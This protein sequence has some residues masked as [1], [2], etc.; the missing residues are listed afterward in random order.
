MKFNKEAHILLAKV[1][2]V[3]NT[4][5]TPAATDCFPLLAFTYDDGT[6]EIDEKRYLGDALDRS[7][8]IT[9]KDQYTKMSGDMYMPIVG[10]AIAVLSDFKTAPLFQASGA[11]VAL[12]GTTTTAQIVITNTIAQSTLLTCEFRQS[13]T[14]DSQ[15]NIYIVPN[16]IATMDFS[17]VIGERVTLKTNIMGNFTTPTFGAGVTPTYGTQKDLKAGSLKSSN[18]IVSE[19][20]GLL[21]GF[22]HTGAAGTVKNVCFEKITCTNVFGFSHERF[23]TSCQ[24][25]FDTTATVGDF[26]ITVLDK[27]MVAAGSES[28]LLWSPYNHSG[29]KHQFTLKYGVG[30][31]K[32]VSIHFSELQLVGWSNSTVKN[33]DAKDLKFRNTGKVTITLS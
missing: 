10:S 33:W 14:E 19:I 2:P 21:G 24:E 30:Q 22:S 31:G 28:A 5:V 9:I 17:A 4:P 15:Q 12:T 13:T 7:A 29:D 27:E 32:T 16:A 8:E 18:I 25:S 6:I 1:Q 3:E 23:L 11:N 20:T 26:T